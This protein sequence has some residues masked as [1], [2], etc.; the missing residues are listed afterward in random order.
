MS[1][2]RERPALSGRAR[3]IAG[4]ALVVFGLAGALPGWAFAQA[5]GPLGPGPLE[6]VSRGDRQVIRTQVELGIRFAEM[7]Q[8][9]ILK[10]GSEPEELKRAKA[11]ARKSYIFLRYAM[12]GVDILVNHAEVMMYEKSLGRMA[13]TAIN[14]A[15]E[16]NLAAQRAIDNSIPWPETR[17]QYVAEA[18]RELGEAIP[19]ARRAAL[20]LR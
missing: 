11:L 9:I 10:Q 18:V 5:S 1:E 12:H 20:L 14:Q 3:T 8:E 13:L 7:A 15:R 6:Y 2:P 17:E 16:R 4:V 19:V